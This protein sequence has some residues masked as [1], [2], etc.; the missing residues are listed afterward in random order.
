MTPSFSSSFFSVKIIECATYRESNNSIQYLAQS[1][2][3]A[4]HKSEI[5][6]RKRK[7]DVS[8]T[9]HTHHLNSPLNSSGP[10]SQRHASSRRSKKH[11]K[12][13]QSSRS[14]LH[15]RERRIR[16]H[17]P[18]LLCSDFLLGEIRQ[19][20]FVFQKRKHAR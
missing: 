14:D 3:V 10:T 12:R 7:H 20:H 1:Y 15:P 5:V 18:Q 17:L 19:R 8:Y 11:Q 2:Y 13:S 16:G 4:R 6:K 9:K